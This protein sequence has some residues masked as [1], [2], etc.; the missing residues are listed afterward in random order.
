MA[1]NG[2]ARQEQR[3]I[4]KFARLKA[5]A[6][7][8]FDL[9]NQLNSK[10]DAKSAGASSQAAKLQIENERAVARTAKAKIIA[11]QTFATT[12]EIGA[13]SCKG[14]YFDNG[15]RSNQ[16][17]GKVKEKKKGSAPSFNPK[18]GKVVSKHG[19]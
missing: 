1:R 19:V 6:T 16:V 3:H 13:G 10:I 8:K 15:V 12:D 18:S 5:A 14:M 9:F 4:Q 7:D 17:R 11:R 2:K